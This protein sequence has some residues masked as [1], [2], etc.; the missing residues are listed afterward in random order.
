M[1]SYD[2]YTLVTC[3]VILA[4][5][6]HN[7]FQERTCREPAQR[8]PEPTPAGGVPPP[9]RRPREASAVA[10]SPGLSTDALLRELDSLQD[11]AKE[12]QEPPSY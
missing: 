7:P 9:T 5:Q 11:K 12:Q 3:L 6:I 2:F 4:L 1:G 8:P 10:S